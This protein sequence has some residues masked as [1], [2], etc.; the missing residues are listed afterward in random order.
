MEWQQLSGHL[1]W[2]QSLACLKEQSEARRRAPA[3]G[4]CVSPRQSRWNPG[5]GQPVGMALGGQGE[6]VS[7]LLARD[8]LGWCPRTQPS[9]ADELPPAP[10]LPVLL[11]RLSWPFPGAS[12]VASRHVPCLLPACSAGGTGD[13]SAWR[14][15]QRGLHFSVLRTTVLV[16]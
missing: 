2:A 12:G 9:P 7:V 10:C 14:W 11:V 6:A 16:I 13:L 4:G 15:A 1:L 3:Q 5:V 8:G